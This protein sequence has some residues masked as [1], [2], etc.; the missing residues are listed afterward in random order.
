MRSDDTTWCLYLSSVF[1]M[2]TEYKAFLNDLSHLRD[3]VIAISAQNTEPQYSG[4]ISVEQNVVILKEKQKLLKQKLAELEKTQLIPPTDVDKVDRGSGVNPMRVSTTQ[5]KAG[6]KAKSVVVSSSTDGKFSSAYD[7]TIQEEPED[8]VDALEASAHKAT[9]TNNRET[10]IR[11]SNTTRPNDS[12]LS[13]DSF[14]D[15]ANDSS[16]LDET[17]GTYDETSEEDSFRLSPDKRTSQLGRRA[18]Q[19]GYPT[20]AAKIK[21]KVSVRQHPRLLNSRITENAKPRP[22]QQ[23]LHSNIPLVGHPTKRA[24]VKLLHFNRDITVDDILQKGRRREIPVDVI[25]NETQTSMEHFKRRTQET[26]T[27]VDLIP[28]QPVTL[29]MQCQTELPDELSEIQKQML[30]KADSS[31]EKQKEVEKPAISNPVMMPPAVL[32]HVDSHQQNVSSLE[33]AEESSKLGQ[34]DTY[35]DRNF[36]DVVDLE[37]SN[38]PAA[39]VTQFNAPPSEDEANTKISSARVAHRRNDRQNPIPARF[40]DL[41]P[42]KAD[43]TYHAI[44][45]SRSKY[46]YAR[47]NQ[48]EEAANILRDEFT[49]SDGALNRL[50]KMLGDE[51]NASSEQ[52]VAPSKVNVTESGEQSVLHVSGIFAANTTVN[53]PG[54]EDEVQEEMK[55]AWELLKEL[56]AHIGQTDENIKP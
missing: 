5:I 24:P 52:P 54:V 53:K 48:I 12:L 4:G 1:K 15:T 25:T 26:G 31:A 44:S 30:S 9:N 50:E 28:P 46:A 10:R 22:H 27:T 8:S 37:L 36:L 7:T 56:E 47:I 19:S 21:P 18:L 17:S 13:E 42:S 35:Y 33:K 3:E 40:E 32:F 55:D 39:I 38:L 49:Q 20:M 11:D 14:T 51:E 6:K 2:E 43:E 16:L 34:E 23:L 41:L 29:E 45:S